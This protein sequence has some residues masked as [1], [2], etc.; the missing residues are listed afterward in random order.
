MRT[1]RL[2]LGKR[3]GGNGDYETRE[4]TREIFQRFVIDAFGERCIH[5]FC[6]IGGCV[7]LGTMM[8]MKPYHGTFH[9]NP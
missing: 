6:I 7:W 4:V 1:S 2:W 3:R 5:E 9:T 8:S